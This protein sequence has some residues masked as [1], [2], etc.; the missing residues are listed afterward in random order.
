MWETWDINI[1]ST[2]TWDHRGLCSFSW[3]C[4]LVQCCS[5][6]LPATTLLFSFGQQKRTLFLTNCQVHTK[7]CLGW[8]FWV[9]LVNET[10]LF[11][12]VLFAFNDDWTVALLKKNTMIMQLFVTN[13]STCN[14]QVIPVKTSWSTS[15]KSYVCIAR[16]VSIMA[17][18]N[19]I[20][21]LVGQQ[22]GLL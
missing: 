22:K 9:A 11:C 17:N 14:S 4:L 3:P 7:S 20:S 12:K 18:G 19:L 1:V 21:V 16:S 8:N 10:T 5:I 15:Y 13:S 6:L 2:S